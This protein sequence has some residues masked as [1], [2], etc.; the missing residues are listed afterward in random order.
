MIKLNNETID[1]KS[2]PNG[3]TLVDGEKIFKAR[4]H[5]NNKIFLKYESDLDLTNLMFLK[6]HLDEDN[7]DIVLEIG[8]MPYSR[9]D[10]VEGASVFTLKY[11]CEF[12]NSLK[13]KQVLVHE[14][15]SDVTAALLDRVTVID[16]S[17]KL[18]YTVMGIVGF[19]PNED[20]IFYPDAGAQKRYGKLNQ[21]N[22][23]VGFKKRDF[24]TGHIDSL[25]VIGDLK[26]DKKIIIVDDLSSRGGTFIYAAKELKK[27]GAGDIYLVVAH[28]EETIFSGDIPESD[29]I[30]KVYTTD[31]IISESKHE[32]IEIIKHLGENK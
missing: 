3:E 28:C 18:L 10:R 7:L 31:S 26:H 21:K 20:Y 11:V 23:L 13:F 8:Y 9:M 5:S 19:D 14:A 27:M 24:Q 2:F 25:Q 16:E 17:V 30:K 6:R 32:K 4:N 1:F 29:L 22:E 12:I 15:H